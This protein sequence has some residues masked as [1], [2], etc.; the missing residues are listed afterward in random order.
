MQNNVTFSFG[1]DTSRDLLVP[2]QSITSDTANTPLLSTVIYAYIDSLVPHIWLPLEAC[3]AFQQAFGLTYNETAELYFVNDTLHEK[4]V[5]QNPNVTCTLGPAS[6]GGSTV[7]VVMQYGSFDLTAEHP[8][9]NNATQYFPLRQAKNDS[10]YTLGRAFLQDAY[11]IADYDRSNFS[12]SQAVLPNSSNIQRIAAIHRPGDMLRST[13]HNTLSTDDKIGIVI[14][15]VVSSLMI[16]AAII[17]LVIHRRTKQHV[18]MGS[19][20]DEGKERAETERGVRKPENMHQPHYLE[21]P[22]AEPKELTPNE[23][24]RP[25][26]PAQPRFPVYEMPEQTPEL[27]DASIAHAH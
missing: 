20:G 11:V 6:A 10:Q 1:P 15:V 22:V 26:L 2:I 3:Q 5:S 12:V 16:I 18:R 17:K 24:R 27:E 9:V 19:R 21:M 4:L 14:G 23:A 8:I 13:Y 7:N 25:E